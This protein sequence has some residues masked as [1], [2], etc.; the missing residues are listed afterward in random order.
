MS[1]FSEQQICVPGWKRKWKNRSQGQSLEC[2]ALIFTITQILG[3]Y[4]KLLHMWASCLVST[5]KESKF[6]RTRECDLY[7][8]GIGWIYRRHA[9]NYYNYFAAKKISKLSPPFALCP[10]PWSHMNQK[11]YFFR[12]LLSN[13]WIYF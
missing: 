2:I 6:C 5:P 12:F 9:I 8:I 7:F 3:G 13:I 10:P 1:T 4:N 11:N